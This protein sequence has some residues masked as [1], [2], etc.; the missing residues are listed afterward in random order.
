MSAI[1]SAITSRTS[2]DSRGAVQA[3]AA[4]PASST[5][6][7]RFSV[8]R[9]GSLTRYWSIGEEGCA[10]ACSAALSATFPAVLPAEVFAVL[11]PGRLRGRRAVASEWS[12]VAMFDVVPPCAVARIRSGALLTQYHGI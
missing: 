12:R 1:G 3:A 5:A 6:R 4:L 10:E 9:S 2:P 7:A 8:R 11:S